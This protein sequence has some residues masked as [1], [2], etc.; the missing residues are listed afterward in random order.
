ME[1]DTC[2]GHYLNL[3]C[4]LFHPRQEVTIFSQFEDKSFRVLGLTKCT[5]VDTF[6]SEHNR[7]WILEAHIKL[8]I[9]T[10]GKLNFSSIIHYS[11][12]KISLSAKAM[13]PQWSILSWGGRDERISFMETLSISLKNVLYAGYIQTLQRIPVFSS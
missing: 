11:F 3:S 13:I 8:S 4:A 5:F 6:R 9:S 2:R 1:V 12:P 10:F 7:F